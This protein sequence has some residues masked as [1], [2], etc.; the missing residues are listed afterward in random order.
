MSRERLGWQDALEWLVELAGA[1]RV[2][3]TVRRGQHEVV[4][5]PWASLDCLEVSDAEFA[6]TIGGS[7]ARVS[8]DMFRYAIGES[9]EHGMFR[10]LVCTLGETVLAIEVTWWSAYADEHSVGRG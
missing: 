5:T 6:T 1:P 4:R 3:L 8:A 2:R 9:R 7:V 10:S